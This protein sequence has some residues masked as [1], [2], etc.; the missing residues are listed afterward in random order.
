MALRLS[1]TNGAEVATTL[2]E[3]VASMNENNFLV[4]PH[5]ELVE[6]FRTPEAWETITRQDL[7]ALNDRVAKLP[8]QLDP[9]QEEAK[10]FDVVMLNAELG[11]L[12]GESFKRQRNRIIKIASALE[13]L[14]TSIP[15]VAEQQQLIADIQTDEWWVDVSYPMLEDARKRLRN[16]VH[17]IERI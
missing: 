14:G 17:L 7:A 12:R 11:V 5:L 2:R 1:A 6:R 3:T 13:D 16:L 8:D 10:R 4:R 9:E 15:V